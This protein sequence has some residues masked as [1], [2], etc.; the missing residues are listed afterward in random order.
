MYANAKPVSNR[1]LHIS[2][3]IRSVTAMRWL[4]Q[5]LP[6][7]W[8]APSGVGVCCRLGEMMTS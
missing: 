4:P 5:Y 2:R 8:D 3:R 7:I 1:F 6:Q